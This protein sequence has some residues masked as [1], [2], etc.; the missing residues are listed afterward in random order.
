[1]RRE[2]PAHTHVDSGHTHG[3]GSLVPQYGYQNYIG[4]AGTGLTGTAFT[5]NSNAGSGSYTGAIVGASAAGVAALSTVGGNA[6]HQNMQ[7][8][9]FA[10]M[11]AQIYAGV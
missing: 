7:P 2:M 6:A 1:M 11:S 4:A 5:S 3:P 10:A 9:Q 8:T